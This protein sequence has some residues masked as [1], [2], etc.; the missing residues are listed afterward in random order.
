MSDEQQNDTPQAAPPLVRGWY[1]D[2]RGREAGLDRAPIAEK[3]PTGVMRRWATTE[4]V[5]ALRVEV[6]AEWK[7]LCAED[8]DQ[9]LWPEAEGDSGR[10]PMPWGHQEVV[11]NLLTSG[12]LA[13]T[14]EGAYGAVLVYWHAGICEVGT[15]RNWRQVEALVFVG[16]QG[17]DTCAGAVFVPA[18]CAGESRHCDMETPEMV[19]WAIHRG[20]SEERELHRR[21]EAAE[22]ELTEL[23]ARAEAALVQERANTVGNALAEGVMPESRRSRRRRRRQTASE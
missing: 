22:T 10:W 21:F 6:D 20:W 11:K 17:F 15:R 1:S 18:G 13:G 14:S 19:P 3:E 16:D 12:R 9:V 8:P 23:R 2:R 4:E 5:E 7:R